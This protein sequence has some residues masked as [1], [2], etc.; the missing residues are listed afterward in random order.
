M[1]SAT[2]SPRGLGFESNDLAVVLGVGEFGH[3]N[4]AVVVFMVEDHSPGT[5]WKNRTFLIGLRSSQER[6]LHSLP[7]L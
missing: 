4:R 2:F 3:Q 5:S 1:R 7:S 6:G